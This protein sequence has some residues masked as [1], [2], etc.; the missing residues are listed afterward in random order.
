MSR[1]YVVRA[2]AQPDAAVRTSGKPFRGVGTLGAAAG[3]RAHA[4]VARPGRRARVVVR[5][6][7]R[8][9][10]G[11]RM[12]VRVAGSSRWWRVGG[13]FADGGTTPLLG[14]GESWTF[15][16]TVTRRESTPAGKRIVVRVAT[17]S[18]ADPSRRDAVSAQVRST[19]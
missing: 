5:V 10:V 6:T 3:Q 16:L 13:R 8:G 14:P 2:P 11:G 9:D 17:R 19:R 18:L 15:R 7:N 12:T 1:T 4:T